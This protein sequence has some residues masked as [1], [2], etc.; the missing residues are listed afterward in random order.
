LYDLLL[1]GGTLLDPSQ[2]I[3]ADMDMAI[4]AGTI[5][6]LAP[7]IPESEAARTIDVRG[8]VVAPGLIDVHAPNQN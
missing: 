1:K 8:K 2:D 3:N 7:S 6:R 5:S 4:T